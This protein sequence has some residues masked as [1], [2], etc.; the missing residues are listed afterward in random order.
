MTD[1]DFVEQFFLQVQKN[2]SY[3][4]EALYFHPTSPAQLSAVKGVNLSFSV[5]TSEMLFQ[6]INYKLIQAGEITQKN[7]CIFDKP[8]YTESDLNKWLLQRTADDLVV[9]PS[10][11]NDIP[12]VGGVICGEIIPPLCHVALLCQNRKTPCC[13]VKDCLKLMASGHFPSTPSTLANGVITTTGFFLDGEISASS[14]SEETPHVDVPQANTSV[15]NL[16]DIHE[17]KE[18]AKDIHVVGAKAAQLAHV[19]SICH[20]PI[21]KG[22]FIIP[23]HHYNKHVYQNTVVSNAVS[24]LPQLSKENPHY[25][26]VHINGF[27]R[28][29]ETIQKEQADDELV[30]SVIEKIKQYNMTSVIF[31]SS[32]NAEDLTGFNGAGLYESVPLFGNSLHDPQQVGAAIKKVWASVWNVK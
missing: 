9:I 20:Q 6:G 26:D 25:T 29:Q 30:Q 32:T 15:T 19:E 13:F 17:D 23:F 4:Y 2:F 22:T 28:F 10:V 5:M 21:F 14:T 3:E 7:V 18:R 11:P 24:K 1:L 16:I 31:R 8:S 27:I 12:V